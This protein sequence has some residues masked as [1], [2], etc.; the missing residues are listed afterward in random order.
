MKV[1]RT[2]RLVALDDRGRLLLICYEDQRVADH[3]HNPTRAP[4]LWATP[5]GGV[6]P[7][8]SFEDGALRELWEE[9]GWRDVPLGPCLWTRQVDFVLN[10]EPIRAD[11]RYYLVRAPRPELDLGNMEDLERTFYREHRWWTLA[12][13]RAS[14]A[15][16][17]PLGLPD[18]LAPILAGEIPLEPIALD[19]SI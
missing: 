5:G 1:R 10:G 2:A 6:N 3:P 7:D 4:F 8:E 12:E 17:F 15:L 19:P 13:L 11:E 16:I 9:T 14:D 18:L